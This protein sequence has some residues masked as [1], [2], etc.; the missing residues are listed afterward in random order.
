MYVFIISL[1]KIM[2]AMI[3]MVAE[4]NND[5]NNIYWS[6]VVVLEGGCCFIFGCFLVD[7]GRWAVFYRP[8]CL[9]LCLESA[10]VL[11]FSWGYLII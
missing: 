9:Q 2:V 1:G 3:I 11:V 8:P 10:S 6:F 7:I 5:G 4:A